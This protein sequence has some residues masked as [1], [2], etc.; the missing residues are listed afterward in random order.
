M[1]YYYADANNQPVGPHTVE[2]LLKLEAAGT[3]Q[4]A[5]WV[6]EE[7][8]TDWKA[9]SDIK[10]SQAAPAPAPM[11]AAAPTP[12]PQAAASPTPQAEQRTLNPQPASVSSAA[13]STPAVAEG[14]DDD[15]KVS[16]LWAVIWFLFCF[17]IGFMMWGQT[18]KGWLWLVIT[19]FTGGVGAVV[20]WIDFWMNWAAQNKRPVGPWEWFPSA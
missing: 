3:I 11:P 18:G 1:K 17:P 2:E 12:T 8:G 6:V 13:A 16:A 15:K 19:F 7:G 14:M 4:A 5:S 20:A 9:F 10:A